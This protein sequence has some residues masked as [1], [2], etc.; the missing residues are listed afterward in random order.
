MSHIPKRED[1]VYTPEQRKQLLKEPRWQYA[2]DQVNPGVLDKYFNFLNQ[3][4][5]IRGDAEGIPLMTTT[6]IYGPI[7]IHDTVTLHQ[8]IDRAVNIVSSVP[9]ADQEKHLLYQLKHLKANAADPSPNVCARVHAK[10][11]S[12]DD[13]GRLPD[14]GNSSNVFGSTGSLLINETDIEFPVIDINHPQFDDT[15][16]YYGA[17][18]LQPNEEFYMGYDKPLFGM[19][20]GKR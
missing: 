12:G 7:G 18:R 16:A 5:V 15:L 4:V 13:G 2:K 17:K 20:Y 14:V 3:G 19:E 10:W 11:I 8:G 1:I 9:V 6:G